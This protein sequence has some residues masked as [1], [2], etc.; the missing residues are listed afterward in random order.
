[1]AFAS[2]LSTKEVRSF[3]I[4]PL[5]AEIHTWSLASGDTSGTVT[6]SRLSEVVHLII[7]LELDAAITYSGNEATI[8]FADKVDSIYGDL[9]LLG[10]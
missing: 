10:R 3:S 9:I 1:M 6:A 2:V 8:S 4:G 5:K 7:G